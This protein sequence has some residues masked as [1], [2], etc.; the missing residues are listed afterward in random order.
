MPKAIQHPPVEAYFTI[1]Q[2]SKRLNVPASLLR[3]AAKQGLIPTHKPF[4]ERVRVR[5][6]EIDAAINVAEKGGVT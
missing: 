5:L 1:P 6:S 4:G 2:A 3:R